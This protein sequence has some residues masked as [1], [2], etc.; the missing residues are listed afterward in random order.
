VLERRRKIADSLLEVLTSGGISTEE[1]W[2]FAQVNEWYGGREAIDAFLQ[3]FEA[4]DLR[5]EVMCGI[6]THCLN[7]LRH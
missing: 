7:G 6:I 2:H 4:E 1:L 3:R 5:Q